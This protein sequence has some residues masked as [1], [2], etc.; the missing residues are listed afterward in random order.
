M[1]KLLLAALL[2]LASTTAVARDIR[3]TNDPGGAI[4]PLYSQYY[5]QWQRGHRH[6]IDGRCAS[7]CT[8][9]LVFENTCVTPRARLGFHRSYFVNFFG[10]KIGSSEGDRFMIDRWP[11]GIRRYVAPRLSHQML[12]LNA[13][14]ARALGVRAC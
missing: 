2:A 6:V 11:N 14:Q 3:V 9:R 5:S 7:A 10:I 8:M 1:V 13:A 4:Q 12:W